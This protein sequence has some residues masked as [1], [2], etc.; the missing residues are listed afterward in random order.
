MVIALQTSN[1][2]ECDFLRAVYELAERSAK[3]TVAFVDA[4]MKSGRSEE[5]ADH[6]CDF[7]ADRG[8]L[9]FTSLGRVALTHI[10]LRRASRLAERGWHSQIPF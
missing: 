2:L 9:E 1:K 6:A 3:R 8:V 10:G 5:E 4:Q 7:W